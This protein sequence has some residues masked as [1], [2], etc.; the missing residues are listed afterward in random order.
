MII[1][2]IPPTLLPFWAILVWIF[3]VLLFP[4]VSG[5]G[6]MQRLLLLL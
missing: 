2:L 4:P 5:K 1:L 3:Q 6:S